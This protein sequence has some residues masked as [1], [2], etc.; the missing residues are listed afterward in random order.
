MV[1]IVMA[2]DNIICNKL[3]RLLNETKIKLDSNSKE[4]SVILIDFVTEYN[5]IWKESL[6]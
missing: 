6:K 2:K 1:K 5:K 4:F 3:N